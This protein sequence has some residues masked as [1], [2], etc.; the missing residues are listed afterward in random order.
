MLAKSFLVLL[1][2]VCGSFPVLASPLPPGAECQA[3]VEVLG[4]V[5]GVYDSPMLPSAI[6][7]KLCRVK[8]LGVV[9]QVKA[10]YEGQGCSWK[11]GD[12]IGNVMITGGFN[13]QPQCEKGEVIEGVLEFAGDEGG[14]WVTLSPVRR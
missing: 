9:K 11:E 10:S 2:V 1:F 12:I 7:V 6:K 4:R 3:N 8:V 14:S 13:P 5:K